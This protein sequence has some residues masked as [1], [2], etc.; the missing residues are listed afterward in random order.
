MPKTLVRKL[1]Q[2]T[3]L[4]LL[5]IG[6]AQAATT[7]NLTGIAPSSGQ[8]GGH[9]SLVGNGFPSCS[10]LSPSN[11][12]VTLTPVAGGSPVTVNPVLSV[13]T[14]VGTFCRIAFQVPSAPAGTY[15]VSFNDPTDDGGVSSAN[16]E[17]FTVSAPAGVSVSGTVIV[18]VPAAGAPL[19]SP[20]TTAVGLAGVTL[21]L[22]P[23]GLTA[24]TNASGQ[25]TIPTVSAGNYT[26]TPS[27]GVPAGDSVT[28]YPP[29][30]SI[31]VGGSNLSGLNFGAQPGYKVTGTFSYK[32]KQSKASPAYIKLQTD[33]PVCAN[34]PTQG[35]AVE[36]TSLGSSTTV[37]KA[38]TVHG[39]PPG[40]YTGE[41][42][43]DVTGFGEPPS[44]PNN[45]FATPFTVTVSNADVAL[46]T[47]TLNDP[48]TYGNVSATPDQPLVMTISQIDDG[49][50][51]SYPSFKVGGL[52]QALVYNVNWSRI[53]SSDCQAGPSV[54]NG[55]ALSV[56][57]NSAV[58]EDSGNVLFLDGD[59]QSSLFYK[60]S[61]AATKPAYGQTWYFCMQAVNG[62]N[63]TS[64]FYNGACSPS[65]P[66]CVANTGYA[67]VTLAAA[68]SS[69][70]SGT[71]TVTM[72]VTIPAFT[73]YTGNT[74]NLEGP[75]YTGCYD[76]STQAY[77][78]TSVQLS[79]GANNLDSEG[80]PTGS[81]FA[82]TVFG[83]PNTA[84][85]TPF[86]GVNNDNDGLLSAT[87]PYATTASASIA[88]VGDLF[89]LKRGPLPT[90][91]AT[92]PL[93]TA[94]PAPISTTTSFNVD[95][96]PFSE[97]SIATLTTQSFGAYTDQNGV[98]QPASYAVNFNVA[99]LVAL[100]Q[101]VQLQTPSPNVNSLMDFAA[102][103]DAFF[104]MSLST[105]PLA[106]QPQ[107][108][109]SYNLLST[110]MNTHNA[111]DQWGSASTTCLGAPCPL[112]VTG[113]NTSLPSGLSA[114]S[115]DTPTFSWSGS[116]PFQ[117]AI[118]DTAGNVL[119][120]VPKT[121]PTYYPLTVTS[122]T[123]PTDP[124]GAGN[125]APAASLTSGTTYV[126][127]VTRFDAN[128]NLA[129]QRAIFTAP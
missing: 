5:M 102:S 91:G 97:N 67:T 120:Q 38:F 110:S 4:M 13:S 112:A 33:G 27:G 10:T 31:T 63:A 45:P 47:V 87:N 50:V 103:P 109:D 125:N 100:P 98:M 49:V 48:T 117:F 39:V 8:A 16:S 80:Q 20:A 41:A 82:Y 65:A 107:L 30:Q 28:F 111:P 106:L 84:N 66:G 54:T 36:L 56:A 121:L 78:V 15:N 23:G 40:T 113:V 53:S 6:I 99:P 94:P 14:M 122:I 119:W 62:N 34:C 79:S 1:L 108:G 126:W 70:G 17:P 21:T 93:Q 114:T 123:Y 26:L 24:T 42:W 22:S 88:S 69:S 18:Q 60:F 90:P 46:G 96:T 71:S 81:P 32:G 73:P 89:N 75:L 3:F 124:T 104:G 12:T 127:S 105:G 59:N 95:L 61:P 19:A 76:R 68:P 72:N 118:T 25:Y 115:S 2:L 77:Y 57:R 7:V 74:V 55:G 9:I 51:I 86:A 92:P 101:T 58:D 29:S 64:S 11:V 85:C 116:S 44:N 128:G 52:E 43:Y 37:T 35:T 83:V 129:T